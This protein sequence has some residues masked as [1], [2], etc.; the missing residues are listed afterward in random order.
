MSE[1][2]QP[3][4]GRGRSLIEQLLRMA[5]TRLE[6]LRAEIQQERLALTSQL[7]LA[8][9]A[10][11]C[12]WLAGLTLLLWVAL[13]LPPDVRSIVLGVLFFVLLL[14][15]IV[16]LALLRRRARREPLFTRII[17]Q[18]RLDRASLSQEP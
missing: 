12:A 3:L 6:L 17:H 13:V 1:P 10:A 7:R 18:L 2:G 11:I 14:V 4:I 15:S 9:A 5:Q 8:A 16:S